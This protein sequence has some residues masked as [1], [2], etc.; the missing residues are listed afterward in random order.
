MNNF[1]HNYVLRTRQL[2]RFEPVSYTHLDVYKRQLFGPS[3][4]LEVRE[5][6]QAHFQNVRCDRA[7]GKQSCKAHI[8]SSISCYTAIKLNIT[9]KLNINLFQTETIKICITSFYIT[10]K[11]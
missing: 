11:C 8:Q 1:Q 7:A 4:Y 2:V 3:D 9:L 6:F 5:V 10:I